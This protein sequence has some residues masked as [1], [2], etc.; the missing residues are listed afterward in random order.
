MNE[1]E[2][3]FSEI[4]IPIIDEKNTTID[5]TQKDENLDCLL[6]AIKSFKEFRDCVESRLNRI[7]EARTANSNVPKASL[8]SD[9][10][11]E[12]SSGFFAD[13]LKDRIVFLESEL[14]QKDTAMKFL[15]EKL[16]EDNCQVVSE[17]IDANISLVQSNDSEESS[18]DCKM[19]KNSCNGTNEQFKKREISI[20]GD[21]LM[22]GIHDKGLS[23][24]HS[25]KVNN[26]PGGTSDAILDKLDDFLKN[27]PDG[28]IVHAG[29]ND[30]TKGKNLLNNV[31]KILKQVKKLSPNTKVA[32]SSIVTRN[33]IKNISK[34]AQD[35]NSR[36]KNTAARKI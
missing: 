12:A 20:V 28:L 27:K 31:K 14:K 4:E 1:D 17:G 13:I 19:I 32:F 2:T 36:L 8:L 30:I 21:S 34:T 18:D 22:N 29:T 23:K 10:D 16:V 5:N 26:I 3:N 9:N 11:V 7:E 6:K 33:Y 25:V 24:N 35:T 15:T